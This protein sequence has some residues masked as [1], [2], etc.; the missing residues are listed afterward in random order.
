[1][2]K[3]SSGD[4]LH[5]GAVRVRV[6]GT[7]NLLV[8]INSLQSTQIDNLTPQAMTSATDRELIS[9]ANFNNQRGQIRIGTS[10]IGEYFNISKIVVFVKPV[11]TGFPQ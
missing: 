3:G 5:F 11:A 4:I 10:Q 7:G 2:A 8:S 9:L 6:S 1:M